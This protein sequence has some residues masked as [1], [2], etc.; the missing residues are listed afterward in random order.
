MSGGAALSLSAATLIFTTASNS[1]IVDT[2]ISIINRA[3]EA[4]TKSLSGATL[5]LRGIFR[6]GVNEKSANDILDNLPDLFTFLYDLVRPGTVIPQ[7]PAYLDPEGNGSQ[8]P[9]NELDLHRE[10]NRRGLVYQ[11][12]RI[13]RTLTII[14]QLGRQPNLDSNMSTVEMDASLP[15][16]IDAAGMPPNSLYVSRL[17]NGHTSK[18][19]DEQWI[20]INGIANEYEWFLRSCDKVRDTFVREVTGVYNRSDGFLWDVI[21]CAGERDAASNSNPLVN[22]TASSLAAR[23]AL[24]REVMLALENK[25]GEK[26]G[27]IVLIAH[28]QGSLIARLVLQRLLKEHPSG[29]RIHADMKERLHVFTFGCPSIDWCVMDSGLKHLRNY[30]K[31]TEHFVHS[32]DYVGILGVVTHQNDPESG[33]VDGTV[34]RS[35]GGRGHLFGAHYPLGSESYENGDSSVLLSAVGGRALI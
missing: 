13:A 30:V 34:F 21:E 6:N 22:S 25:G 24:Y 15:S 28:S 7:F 10:E 33:Y 29:S 18:H 16:D 27:K 14:L 9:Y 12:Q 8:N 35:H 3:F 5:I 32:R 19:Q 26:P 2:I 17:E 4:L 23:D 31:A 20:F 1:A 11:V